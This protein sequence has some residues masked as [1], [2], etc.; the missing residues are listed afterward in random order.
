M[1]RGRWASGNRWRGWTS[2]LS[3][4]LLALLSGPLLANGPGV[5]PVRFFTLG[6]DDG[7]PHSTARA[8][9]QD[10]DG[11][12]WIGSQDGLSR[13]DGHEFEVFRHRPGVLDGLGDN[14]I[15]AL[16][17]DADGDLWI[18]TQAGGL[19]RRDAR[20]GAFVRE[21]LPSRRD[22]QAQEPV[23]ALR[24]DPQRGLW[25]ASGNGSLHRRHGGRWQTEALGVQTP[26]GP[27]RSLRLGR[28]G[29]LL[30]AARHGV[31]RCAGPQD[32][33]DSLRDEE[34]RPIDAQDVIEDGDGSLWT[35][36]TERGLY[37]HA[38][39]GGLL[40]HHH[41]MAATRMDDSVRSLLIDSK[42]R[43]WIATHGGVW[44][45]DADR[46]GLR[47]WRHRPSG[48]GGLPTDRI[49]TLFEDRDGMIWIG[50]WTEGLA[51]L[52]PAT[53]VFTSL[54]AD[55][56]VPGAMPSDV[57][58]ALLAEPDGRLWMGLAP[59]HGLALFDF[60][61]G[62]LRHY[63]HD[64]GQ[65]RS[66]SHNYV[67]S[68]IRDGEGRLWV[69]TQGG[70]LNLLDAD[71]EGFTHF[72]HDPDRPDSLASDH[73]LHLHP[74]ADGS[75][76]IGTL[77]AGLDRLCRG[78]ADFQHFRHDPEDPTSLGG[79]TVSNAFEDSRGRFWVALRPGGLNLLDRESARFTRI[80]ARPGV[81]GSLS[82]DA[83]TVLR[84]DSRGRLWI[85]TQGGGLNLL[86]AAPGEPLRFRSLSRADGLGSDAIGGLY[87][88]ARGRIWISTTTGISRLD[89]ARWL[90]E[91][92]GG[93]EGVQ[94]SG[95]FVGSQ[96]RLADGRIAF[97]GLRGV[98][99]FDPE[100]L[101]AR[102]PPGQVVLTRARSQSATDLGDDQV[103]LAARIQHEG[104][105]RL[106]HPARDLVLEFSALAFNAPQGLRYRHRLEGVDAD[107]V[108]SEPRRRY[109]AYTNLPPGEYRFSM[110]ATGPDLAG[111]ESTIMLRVDPSPLAHPLARLL[112]GLLALALFALLAWLLRSRLAERERA[113][114]AL[115]DSGERLKLALWGTGDELW[116]L[117]LR[118]G[119]MRRVN[120]LP[121]LAAPQEPEVG[122]A[123][124]L[125]AYVHPDDAHLP[126][127]ALRAHLRGESDVFE[128]TY[129]TRDVEG[130]WR[131]LRSR[132]R[133]VERG[134]DGRA[135]RVA[136]TVGDVTQLKH[137]EAQLEALNLA[138][139]MRV[140]ERT[141]ELTRANEA[142][143]GTVKELR[144]AQRQ[145]VDAEKMAALGGLVAGVAHEINTPLG[146]SVTA[147]SHLDG[148][149]RQLLDLIGRDALKRSDLDRYVGLARESAELILRNLRRADKLVRS[150]KQVAVDQGSEAPR[151]LLL[152][153][154]L[155]DI[156]TSLRPV[157]KRS[158]HRVVVDCP[159][160][161][162]FVAQPGA[163]YQIITNLLMNSLTHAFAPGDVGEMRIEAARHGDS[164]QIVYS[165][166][167][168]GMSEEARTRIFEPFFT[169][170]RGQGGS[171][172]GMH[173]VFNL[174]SQVL[175]GTIEC[176]SAPGQGVYFGIRI[177]V[178]SG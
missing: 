153:Q 33:G 45:F 110:Q 90:V 23:S 53:E 116:D 165:D 51:A 101:A 27:I 83:L 58:T 26:T 42:D 148:E 32:C 112:Y 65:P 176:D 152:A 96:A 94:G 104:A 47:H 115:R 40:A 117:D 172:L 79:E 67:Q 88:D 89:P 174:V 98:T 156:L 19:T 91:N 64:P 92:Y 62:V 22:D 167:G 160:D 43:L 6:V 121:F 59:N 145:L 155:D 60:E 13:F 159:A 61:R 16:A 114:Q 122:P 39:D 99:V 50:T 3:A 125:V 56:A 105:L 9:A 128:V 111:P 161:L 57:V 77:D 164:V 66:L 46:R 34:G 171:G 177:P 4:C 12:L 140:E 178:Q 144:L 138:L 14:H 170:K 87:E 63:R 134:A 15:I 107:W 1:R 158:S 28:G 166:N 2:V 37:H 36:S 70:G 146:I 71:G 55:P 103:A 151:H 106:R 31:W 97:G 82:S 118:S 18:G 78:C 113:A 133:V 119:L 108:Y 102:R 130:Q 143:H 69:A 100:R 126:D 141:S 7:L 168:R 54:F 135:L 72:R 137:H 147:A 123:S 93:R 154:Y 136:G 173:I 49:Q 76:W 73:L 175:G 85:G 129:R 169:T 131:W 74:D 149:T 38:A 124:S 10:N 41:G 21:T 109:A 48:A 157:L 24:W 25:A 139:E 150:F 30:V 132:G 95:Y 162:G 142:L 80:I 35:A 120:P 86:D 5:E 81:P 17:V 84:E 75:L 29:E 52:D 20:S 8:L 11:F 163:I 68:I 44:R 127:A